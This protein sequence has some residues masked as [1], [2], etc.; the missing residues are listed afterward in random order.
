MLQPI[1]YAPPQLWIPMVAAT[2]PTFEP[3]WKTVS[4][5]IHENA[6]LAPAEVNLVNS[7][8][9]GILVLLND[10]RSN[11]VQQIRIP[12][13]QSSTV[14]LDR[15]ASST[16]VETYEIRSPGGVWDSQQLVTAVP[17]RPYYDLSIYEDFLQSI[18]I[19]RTGKSPNPIEDINVVPKSVGWIIIPP[20]AQLPQ[21]SNIDVFPQAQAANNPGAVRRL[22]P[23]QF[24]KQPTTNPLESILD[25][26]KNIPRRG[27]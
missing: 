18:A 27:F 13:G 6:P 11:S 19:D 20:G 2:L 26:V 16:I 10:Q 17:P 24:D 5:Q 12:A 25:E 21:T 1:S 7:H 4:Q 22:D 3:F 23:R 8:R 9:S 15:D 14:R